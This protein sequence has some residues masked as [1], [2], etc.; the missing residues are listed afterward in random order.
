M[1]S[2]KASNSLPVIDPAAFY[3]C[4]FKIN[5]YRIVDIIYVLEWVI[6]IKSYL[7]HVV[8]L[9]HLTAIYIIYLE[10]ASVFLSNFQLIEKFRKNSISL[11]Y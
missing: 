11:P 5:I 2:D 9:T 8:L 7:L 10:K 4:I 3:S 1:L 6:C